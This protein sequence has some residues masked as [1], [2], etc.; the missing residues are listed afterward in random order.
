MLMPDFLAA[1]LMAIILGIFGWV[2]LRGVMKIYREK[3]G[4]P[5]VRFFAIICGIILGSMW[6]GAAVFIIVVDPV[7]TIFGAFVI[8]LVVVWMLKPEGRG[9]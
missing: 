7:G 8:A 3:E 9:W 4:N 5:F 6:L 1:P 2:A